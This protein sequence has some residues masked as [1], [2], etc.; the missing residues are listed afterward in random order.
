MFSILNDRFNIVK[1]LVEKGA[2]VTQTEINEIE[3]KIAENAGTELTKGEKEIQSYLRKK[4]AEQH[5]S[6]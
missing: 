1:Y 2:I 5:K 6:S 3:N 4:Y